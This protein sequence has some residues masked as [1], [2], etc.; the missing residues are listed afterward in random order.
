M[1]K[2]VFNEVLQKADKELMLSLI[3][4]T[5]AEM[6]NVCQDILL[7]YLTGT[8]RKLVFVIFKPLS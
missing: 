3:P 6:G 5:V 1:T 7:L 8:C 4:F 2:S